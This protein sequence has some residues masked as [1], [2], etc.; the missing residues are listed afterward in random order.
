MLEVGLALSAALGF[1]VSSVLARA[2][3]QQIRPTTGVLVSLAVGAVVTMAI[4]FGLH[5][6]E[7][8]AMT[9]VG[10]AW[11]LLVGALHYPV[12][13][14]FSYVGIRF[15]GAARSSPIVG[16]SPMI[17]TV[18]AITVGSESVNAPI[19]MGTGTIMAGLVIILSEQ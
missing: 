16:I 11:I 17:A 13:R 14:L 3:L 12:G 4:A 8:L 19:L 2:G 10:F 1:G 7:I 9:A 5:T 6:A 18:L 15:V